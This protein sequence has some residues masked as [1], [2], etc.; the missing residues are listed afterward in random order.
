MTFHT[1]H[2]RVQNY[3]VF[4]SIKQMNLLKFVM[5]L[6]MQYNL[7]IIGIMKFLIVFFDNILQVKKSGSK[8]SINYN[9]ARIRIDSCN[10]LPTEKILTFRNVIILIKSV[11]NKVQNKYYYNIKINPIHNILK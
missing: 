11:V 4:G 7:V 1:K 5:E 2:L 3:C 6:D 9:F 10:S 8:D